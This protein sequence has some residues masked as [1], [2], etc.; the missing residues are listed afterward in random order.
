VG[1]AFHGISPF[2]GIEMSVKGVAIMLI[3]GLGSVY[4]AMVGGM[5]LGI[6]EIMTVA[7]LASSFRDAFSFILLIA[8]LLLRPQGLFA[9]G[10]QAGRR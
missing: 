4:G 3:G 5:L 1:F 10:M 6:V 7:Y 2:M 9:N 8:V